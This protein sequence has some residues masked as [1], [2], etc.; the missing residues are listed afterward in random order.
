VFVEVV[1]VEEVGSSE[2]DLSE[3]VVLVFSP[4]RQVP[5]RRVLGSCYQSE[6]CRVLGQGGCGFLEQVKGASTSLRVQNLFMAVV[7]GRAV[8]GACG[9]EAVSASRAGLGSL[10]TSQVGRNE[11][12][13]LAAAASPGGGSKI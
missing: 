5:S 12:R 6:C 1:R 10:Y 4:S 9:S 8:T 7:A 11:A 3:K 2:V 13:G